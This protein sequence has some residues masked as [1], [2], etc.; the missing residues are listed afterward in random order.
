MNFN[1]ST[2]IK[3]NRLANAQESHIG[4][5]VTPHV[6]DLL[7]PHFRAFSQRCVAWLQALFLPL[8]QRTHL[9]QSLTL[10]GSHATRP[11]IP[12]RKGIY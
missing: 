10:A 2:F 12:K 1:P 4:Y 8:F 9:Q 6:L 5:C 11:P 3:G 7:T